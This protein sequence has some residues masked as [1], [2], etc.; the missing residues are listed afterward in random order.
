MFKVEPDD[1]LYSLQSHSHHVSQHAFKKML[2]EI[3]YWASEDAAEAEFNQPTP[4]K[5]TN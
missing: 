1:D 4:Q 2:F 3:I 5:Y